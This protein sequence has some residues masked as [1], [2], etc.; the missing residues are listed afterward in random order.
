MS[1]KRGPGR[2]KGSTSK[3]KD[4]ES[5]S[6]INPDT[7]RDI[8]AIVLFIVAFVMLVSFFGFGGPWAV[9]STKVYGWGLV[10]RLSCYRLS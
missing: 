5:T 8:V 4:R 6:R 10:G 1:R 3:T 7:V 9:A 2:P